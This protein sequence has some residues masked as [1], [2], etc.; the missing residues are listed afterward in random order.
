MFISST[1]VDFGGYF[2]QAVVEEGFYTRPNCDSFFGEGVEDF[3]YR[4]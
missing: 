4:I 2:K 3:R 1:A